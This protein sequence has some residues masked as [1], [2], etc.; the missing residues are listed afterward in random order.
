MTRKN[1]S[2]YKDGLSV[3]DISKSKLQHILKGVCI[4]TW[5]KDANGHRVKIRVRVKPAKR[6]SPSQEIAMLKRLLRKANCPVD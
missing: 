6:L 5:Y 3:I 2:Q 4:R 1:Y